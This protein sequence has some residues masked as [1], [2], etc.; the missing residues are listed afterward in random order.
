M[1]VGGCQGV[2]VVG[3]LHGGLAGDVAVGGESVPRGG[4]WVRFAEFGVVDSDD[5]DS[6]VRVPGDFVWLVP[7]C[8]GAGVC[9]DLR[10]IA[11]E[12]GWSG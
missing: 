11:V 8:G 5:G 9:L 4:S 10:P 1:P 12:E 7:S 3:C 2:A 6:R